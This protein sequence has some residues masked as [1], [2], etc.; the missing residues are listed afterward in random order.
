MI[1]ELRLH[2]CKPAMRLERCLP[3]VVALTIVVVER[4]PGSI[5]K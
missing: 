3:H 1:G 5:Q 4:D 2:R